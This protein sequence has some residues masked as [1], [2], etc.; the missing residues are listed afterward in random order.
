[1]LVALALSMTL[2]CTA[3]K[4]GPAPAAGGQKATPSPGSPAGASSYVGDA[5]IRISGDYS[6]RVGDCTGRD[7]SIEGQ[8]NTVVL[9]GACGTVTIGGR[10]NT[11]DVE[12]ADTIKITGNS[13]TANAETLGAVRLD[14]AYF[15]TV[16]WVNGAG[17]SEPTVSGS[18][19]AYTVNK[20][21]RQ[22]YESRSA[23]R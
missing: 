15:V 20:I 1:M 8:A 23:L 13:S 7:V 22:D 14:G 10:F 21:S 11:V 19:R 6:R 18:G 9:T 2:G 5:S 17:G 16:N 4:S 12:A 3:D